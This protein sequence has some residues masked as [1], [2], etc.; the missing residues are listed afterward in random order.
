MGFIGSLEFYI[1]IF[2]LFLI[3]LN[4]VL[5]KFGLSINLNWSFY[6]PQKDM[7]EDKHKNPLGYVFGFIITYIVGITLILFSLIAYFYV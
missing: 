3:I 6:R 7:L 4:T 1:F 2:G 5:F